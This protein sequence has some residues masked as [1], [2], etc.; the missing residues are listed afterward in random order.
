MEWRSSYDH[1]GRPATKKKHLSKELGCNPIHGEWVDDAGLPHV[2]GIELG[3]DMP[4]TFREPNDG[5]SRHAT[6]PLISN[7]I[8]SEDNHID[9]STCC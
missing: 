3:V 7:C 8:A 2:M 5:G 1:L 6:P 9:R 4:N